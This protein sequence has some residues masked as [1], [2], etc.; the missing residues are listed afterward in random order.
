MNRLKGLSRLA[1]LAALAL[2]TATATVAHA[3]P[4]TLTVQGQLTNDAGA[5]RDGSYTLTLSLWTSESGGSRLFTQT[6]ADVEVVGGFFDLA[7]GGDVLAP[8]TPE[9]FKDNAQ[10][11]LQ[12]EVDAG[13]GVAPNE[14][15][16]PRQPL[17]STPFA[18]AAHHAVTASSA[19]T[20]NTANT[21]STAIGLA[22][23]SGCVSLGELDFDPATQRELDD[24]L[25][26]VVTNSAL[27]TALAPY[28]KT[29]DLAA[30]ATLSRLATELAE[31]VTHSE[32]AAALAVFVTPQVLA[33][34]L[35]PYALKTSL[36]RSVDGLAGGSLTSGVS[37]P[38]FTQGGQPVCDASGNCGRSVD[39]LTCADGQ[40]LVRSGGAWICA[41][42]RTVDDFACADGQS[43]VRIGGQWIC[44]ATA[45]A[46][47]D[48]AGAFRALQFQAGR[49]SCVDLRA[50]GLSGGKARGFEAI[51][52]W[53]YAWDGQ[54]RPQSTW[55]NAEAACAADGGR[56][57]TITELTRVNHASGAGGV[58]DGL[59]TSWHWSI[60]PLYAGTR[61][62][63]VRLDTGASSSSANATELQRYR[64][65]WPNHTSPAF[66]GNKC[67]GPPGAECF[68]S[69]SEGGRYHADKFDRPAVPW[70]VAVHECAFY[71]ARVARALTYAELIQA[72]LPNGGAVDS[73][74]VWLWASDRGGYDG[75][76]FQFTILRWGGTQPA[77]DGSHD[78][79]VSWH[80]NAEVH[81]ARFRCVG[82]KDDLGAYAGSVANE[83]VDVGRTR[84]KSTT[85]ESAALE[86]W[87]TTLDRCFAAGGH[88]P[89]L[90]DWTA[91][92]QAG[93]PRPNNGDYS[94]T[95]D[96]ELGTI[97]AAATH[98]AV[99][100][101]AQAD[102]A[103]SAASPTYSTWA[104]RDSSQRGRCV[105]YPL[106]PTYAGPSEDSCNGGCFQ[107]TVEANGQRHR[108]W[109]DRFDRTPAK[110]GEAIRT[111]H[112][113]GGHLMSHAEH[114]E[115]IRGGLPNGSNVW[116]WTS[117][118]A[119]YDQVMTVRWTGTA[120]AWDSVANASV[121]LT[122]SRPF[123]F[124][125]TALTWTS[126]EADCVARGGHLAVP[127]SGDIATIRAVSGDRSVWLG[128]SDAAVEGTWTSVWG[129]LAGHLPWD[130]GQPD[131]AGNNE[132]CGHI[133]AG[134]NVFNDGPCTWTLPYVCEGVANEAG[135]VTSPVTTAPYRCLWSNELNE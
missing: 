80:P 48:C 5:A 109:V 9:I 11:W 57:P 31:L 4:S 24:A 28:A 97:A 94:H 32:L 92:I 117:D 52:A 10:V 95:S 91:L 98:N 86:P 49:W 118:W 43:L 119:R 7:L 123:T 53:G 64:C 65:V 126:A 17:T 37:A 27:T 104:P 100:R 71:N 101:W 62:M 60:T 51:D 38:S 46:P 79:F 135:G 42:R 107:K 59:E 69:T 3:V 89:S 26:N 90:A 8:L 58:G 44:A 112:Q 13:P 124:F 128:L 93:L 23:A 67:Y 87:A 110:L 39:D 127:L 132:D 77:F 130:A 35:E 66:N 75:S 20:A 74:Q 1:A 102:P 85:T 61:Y 18:F 19:N 108:F 12:I 55:A 120:P 6:I 22:C 14:A 113:R 83:F 81:V 21:A 36:P 115:L 134:R 111:C 70:W 133:W 56:L 73:G 45:S 34:A 106:D 131:N 41:N 30:Y 72:G 29:A 50:S 114:A 76:R 99:V 122:R 54:M 68:A 63:M 82:L 96:A 25:T 40:E 47:P 125:N 88:I 105:W 78:T 2:T 15:P 103:F 129:G 121:A 33:A 84:L 116:S 16:L